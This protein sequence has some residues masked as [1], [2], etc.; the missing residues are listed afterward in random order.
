MR[1]IEITKTNGHKDAIDLLDIDE[2]SLDRTRVSSTFEIRRITYG[3]FDA[4]SAHSKFWTGYVHSDPKLIS[5]I[6]YVVDGNVHIKVEEID[7]LFY[8]AHDLRDDNR[9]LV[10]GICEVTKFI[11]R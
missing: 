9:N 10:P 8:S 3:A 5:K 1:K 6:E 11:L 7:S 4:S 2:V